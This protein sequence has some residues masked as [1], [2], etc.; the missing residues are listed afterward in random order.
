MLLFSFLYQIL[1]NYAIFNLLGEYV[2][3]EEF[4][5]SDFR[6]FV[7]NDGSISSE[8][9]TYC[10]KAECLMHFSFEKSDC[11]LMLLDIQGAGDSL[12]DPEIAS[13]E[14]LSEEDE[15][16]FCTGNLSVEA[17]SKFCQNHSCNAYCKSIGLKTL[18]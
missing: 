5:K 14:L 16:Q 15:Y 3:I 17:I 2:T 18:H 4:I 8:K 12:C 9:T 11:K 13:S 1:I 6:K 10:Q 7:N